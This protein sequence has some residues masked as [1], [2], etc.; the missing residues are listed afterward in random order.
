M[1][2]QGGGNFTR[3][4][5]DIPGDAGPILAIL[6][7]GPAVYVEIEESQ[8]TAENAANV[9]QGF[10]YTLPNDGFV[11]ELAVIPGDKASIG[12]RQGKH[13]GGGFGSILGNASSFLIGIGATP[14]TV[15]F[16]AQSLTAT[17]TSIQVTQW[18]S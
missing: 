16:K 4:V 1:S 6:A 2:R 8:V 17:A 10:V 7:T 15:L 3:T 18:F 14:A 9:P 13:A 5:I 11:Q 12:D